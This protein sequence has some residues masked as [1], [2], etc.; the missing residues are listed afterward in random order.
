MDI[1]VHPTHVDCDPALALDLLEALSVAAHFDES[2]YAGGTLGRVVF[3]IGKLKNTLFAAILPQVLP[4]AMH[5]PAQDVIVL[6]RLFKK[7]MSKV[8]LA[9]RSSLWNNGEIFAQC[10]H[11]D[12]VLPVKNHEMLRLF[13]KTIRNIHWGCDSAYLAEI[14]QQ[15]GVAKESSQQPV[16]VSI[17]DHTMH[18]LMLGQECSVDTEIPLSHDDGTVFSGFI[19]ASSLILLQHLNPGLVDL[20]FGAVTPGHLGFFQENRMIV[21]SAK[22]PDD[23]KEEKHEEI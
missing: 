9:Q 8:L 4:S 3:S 18:I 6:H 22:L 17:Q 14:S 2:I 5:I 13:R 15:I 16:N 1:K 11:N 21:L 20:G 12:T 7:G 10:Q 23:K 19:P